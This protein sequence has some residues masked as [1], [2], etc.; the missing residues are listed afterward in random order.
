MTTSGLFIVLEGI[1][2][3][4]TTTQARRLVEALRARG[5]DCLSTCEPS[6]GRV[7]Q[8]LRQL[9]SAGEGQAPGWEALALLFAA[10]RAD[11]HGREI[12]P[13]LR[14]GAVVVCDRY[15]LSSLTYQVATAPVEE[16]EAFQWVR[17]LNSR[18]GRPDLT[19]VLQV[20]PEVALRRRDTRGKRAELFEADALQRRLAEHYADAARL[21][22]GDPLVFLD[23][24][25]P[26]EKVHDE[27][28]RCVEP[29][30]R[31]RA[32]ARRSEER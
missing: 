7:G 3:S 29:Q 10:D 5:H 8:L 12:E 32:G 9:L 24:E 17:S 6:A 25:A 30:L 11:H 16:S 2:G 14:R 23:G 19:F 18:V 20:A 26:V 28:W 31:G 4:G 15:D 22:P 1:D 13:A 27:L 21:V